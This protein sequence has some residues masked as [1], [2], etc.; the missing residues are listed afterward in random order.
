MNTM[1]PSARIRNLVAMAIFSALGWSFAAVCTAADSTEAPS[2]IVKYADLNVSTPQGA[3]ALYGRIRWAAETV[4]RPLDGRDLASQ[5]R[6]AACID[7]AIA[8]AVTQV[9]QPALFT[10]YNAKNKTP[11]PAT[12]VSQSH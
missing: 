5:S 2:V 7:H 1:T 3:A 6:K 4:C 10:V 11:L 9:N 12:L 8:T